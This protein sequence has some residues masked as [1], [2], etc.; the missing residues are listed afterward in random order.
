MLLP[1]NNVCTDA[2]ECYVIYIA[3]LVC[4]VLITNSVFVAPEHYLI[5]FCTDREC[6]YCAVRTGPLHIIHFVRSL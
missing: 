3:S 6:V 1:G 4:M 5:G 2:P